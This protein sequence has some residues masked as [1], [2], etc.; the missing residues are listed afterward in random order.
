MQGCL[1]LYF[2][3]VREMHWKVSLNHLLFVHPLWNIKIYYGHTCILLLAWS[4][5]IR[6]PVCYLHV[7]FNQTSLFICQ[8][9]FRTSLFLSWAMR[10]PEEV[11]LSKIQVKIMFYDTFWW[12]AVTFKFADQWVSCGLTRTNFQYMHSIW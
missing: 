10:V 9:Y 1:I 5:Y 11:L 12:N 4:I 2:L 7:C 8:L 3:N 6:P